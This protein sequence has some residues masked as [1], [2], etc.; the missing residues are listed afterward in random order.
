MEGW[1]LVAIKE[2]ERLRITPKWFFVVFVV[3]LFCLK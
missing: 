1:V 3:V 2:K